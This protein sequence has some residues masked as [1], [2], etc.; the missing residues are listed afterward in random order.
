MGHNRRENEQRL[1]RFVTSYALAMGHLGRHA[2]DEG[3][4]DEA[5]AWRAKGDAVRALSIPDLPFLRG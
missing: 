4:H 1:N 5:A 3:R 2:E